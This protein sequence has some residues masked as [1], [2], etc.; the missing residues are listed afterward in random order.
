MGVVGDYSFQFLMEEVAVAVQY[1][2][3]FVLVMVNNGYMG[4]IRQ[5]EQPYDM[6]TDVDLT[7][8]EAPRHRPCGRHARDGRRWRRVDRGGRD[9]RRAGVGD[10]RVRAR[11]VPVLV[12]VM[13]EREANAAMGKSIDAIV[14]FEPVPEAAEVAA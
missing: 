12:E 14:E 1:R 2:V 13:V 4:L 7:Y 8:G 6:K 3:P 5:A 9:R 11:G 10:R